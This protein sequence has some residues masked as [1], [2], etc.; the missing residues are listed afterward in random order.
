[1]QLGLVA[2]CFLLHRISTTSEV[3]LVKQQ[4]GLKSNTCPTDRPPETACL[5]SLF[6]GIHWHGAH[7]SL[8]SEI[9]DA[10]LPA[11]KR[12]PRKHSPFTPLM[13]SHPACQSLTL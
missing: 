8:I 7:R 5:C 10:S 11:N 12:L 1:M 2:R 13:S 4:Q 9:P 6:A 3:A